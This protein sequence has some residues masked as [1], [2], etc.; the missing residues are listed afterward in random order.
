MYLAA[1]LHR[2]ALISQRVSS[3]W[4]TNFLV[5]SLYDVS[6]RFIS[7]HLRPIAN[8]SITLLRMPHALPHSLKT[9][10]M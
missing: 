8:L 9:Q 5:K 10:A 2:F 4:N 7:V 6:I 3:G 1:D